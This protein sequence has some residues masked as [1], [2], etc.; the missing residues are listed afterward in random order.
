MRALAR[1]PRAPALRQ[2]GEPRAGRTGVPSWTNTSSRRHATRGEMS[3]APL[4]SGRLHRP[5]AHA[6]SGRMAVV[7]AGADLTPALGGN[8]RVSVVNEPG[9]SIRG[10][11]PG[12]H[13]DDAHRTA[14][15]RAACLASRLPFRA[16]RIGAR[17][18]GAG[19]S[20]RIPSYHVPN[21]RADDLA[22]RADAAGV[23][24]GVV[25]DKLFLPGLIKL[26]RLVEGGFFGRVLS[27]RG[28]FGYWVFEGDWQ[29]PQRPAWNYRRGR[30][31][32]HRRQVLSL[33]LR[34][35]EPVR[36]RA[37]RDREDRDAHPPALGRWR[38]V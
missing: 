24:H 15:Q 16:G 12:A 30:G 28:E 6:R 19:G 8:P 29:S 18:V 23:K 37:H 32:H 13:T 11:R 7:C 36:A 1:A 14:A 9:I 21:N 3:A 25:H 2:D 4:I 17:A 31:R 20:G 10:Q 22:R 34:A 26:R 38:S 27:V 33:E 5:E 35:G